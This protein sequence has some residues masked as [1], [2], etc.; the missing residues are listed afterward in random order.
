MR[1]GGVESPG[2]PQQSCN[3]GRSA[4]SSSAQATRFDGGTL[5]EPGRGGKVLHVAQLAREHQAQRL[6]RGVWIGRR[7]FAWE[8]E[9]DAQRRL[10][11]KTQL[12]DIA[13]TRSP[14]SSAS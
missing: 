8:H 4:V 2:T 14:E 12:K 10:A 1:V 7:G 13:A 5:F 9:R 3:A 6:E 11:A